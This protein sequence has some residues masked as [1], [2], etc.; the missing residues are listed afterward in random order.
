LQ[1][2]QT[3]GTQEQDDESFVKRRKIRTK[4]EAI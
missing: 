4:D 3:A 2:R 1:K